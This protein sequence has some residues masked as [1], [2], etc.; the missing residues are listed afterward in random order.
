MRASLGFRS[1]KHLYTD[2]PVLHAEYVLDAD[3]DVK[4][5]LST[6]SVILKPMTHL[7]VFFESR[8]LKATF[9]RKLSDVAC[10]LVHVITFESQKM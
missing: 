5:H 10:T 8:F 2:R 1:K 6:E 3:S 4:V 7:K 9:K